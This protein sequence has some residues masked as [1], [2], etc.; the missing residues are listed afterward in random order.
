MRTQSSS[1]FSPDARFLLGISQLSL[2]L[3]GEISDTVG[4]VHREVHSSTPLGLLP[5]QTH[6]ARHVFALLKH[7]FLLPARMIGLAGHQ[8]PQREVDTMTLSVQAAINGVFGDMLAGQNNP[9]AFGMSLH[10]DTPVAGQPL[11]LF[12]HGLCLHEQYWH[13]PAH[14]AFSDDLSKKGFRV[15]RL[16]YN[17]G[18]P[19][20]ENARLLAE[21]LETTGAS[22]IVL[23]GH[24]MGGLI[25]RSALHQASDAGLRWAGQ[26]T[27][28][29]AIGSPHHGAEAE[30]LGNYANRLLNLTRWSAPLTRLGNL[31]SAAIHDLRF[32]NLLHSDR[33]RAADIFHT[34]DPRE[35]IPLPD[36]VEH[37]F[38]AG[39]RTVE[40]TATKLRSD[41]LVTPASALA[42]EYPGSH[43]VTREL[44]HG[45][46]H[47]QL[48]RDEGVYG[49]M[50]RWMGRS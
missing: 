32:G 16:R 34:H 2:S 15:S 27:H 17:S 45:V 38:V 37:L 33:E 25:S 23:I 49:R 26:T 31:R 20:A 3:A 8:I 24:S 30:R 43:G 10:G 41:L 29:A 50:G 5:P 47:M 40:K 39:T 11:A 6:I 28:L 7:S 14:L 22:R 35:P 36:H 42:E 4:T 1:S 44:L 19:I 21:L 48:L 9:L 18:L 13:N 46:D 12:V